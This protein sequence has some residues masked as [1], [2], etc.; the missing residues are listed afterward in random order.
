MVTMMMVAGARVEGGYVGVGGGSRDEVM[1]RMFLSNVL[2]LFSF[3][4]IVFTRRR[5]RSRK[6]HVHGIRYS[7]L[8]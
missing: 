4:S 8:K 3:L 6:H 7:A 2:V 1:S 5:R